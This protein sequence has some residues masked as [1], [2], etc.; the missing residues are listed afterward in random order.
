[1]VARREEARVEATVARRLVPLDELARYVERRL[2]LD[3]GVTAPAVAEEFDTTER[4]AG[5]ALRELAAG[6]TRGRRA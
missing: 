1:M 2:D 3:E 5:A 6:P 4:I